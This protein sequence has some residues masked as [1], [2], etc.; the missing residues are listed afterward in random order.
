ME[1]WYPDIG[2]E[3]VFIFKERMRSSIFRTDTFAYGNLR[4]LA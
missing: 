4:F 3:K 2:I 1:F